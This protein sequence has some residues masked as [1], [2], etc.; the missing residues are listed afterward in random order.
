MVPIREK[1]VAYKNPQL[2]ELS[3]RQESKFFL[4]PKVQ[5]VWIEKAAQL[6]IQTLVVGILLQFRA[7]LSQKTEV[8]LPQD[9]LS[10]FEISRG[11]KQRALKNLEKAGLILVEQETGRSPSI[12]VLKA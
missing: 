10:R 7:L 1:R 3:L 5:L 4:H 2:E 9:F 12:T 8:T 6:G 11:V